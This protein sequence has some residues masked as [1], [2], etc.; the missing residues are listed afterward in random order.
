[1]NKK[2]FIIPAFLA[3]SLQIVSAIDILDLVLKPFQ[4]VYVGALYLRYVMFIDAVIYFILFLSLAQMV[5][6][7]AYGKKEGKLVAV[8]VGLA[9]MFGMMIFEKN[10]GFNLGQLGP[11]SAIIL[12]MVLGWLLYNLIQGMFNDVAASFSLTF[13]IMYAILMS[14]FSPLYKWLEAYS[15]LLAAILNLTMVAAFV[16][17]IIRII[18][19]FGGGNNNNNNGGGNG[20]TPGTTPTTPGTTP[21]TPTVPTPPAPS[22]ITITSPATGQNFNAG[23]YVRIAFNVAGPGFNHNYDYDVMIDGSRYA[24]RITNIGGNQV[25]P[26]PIRAGMEL[27][28]GRHLIQITAVSRGFFGGTNNIIAQSNVVEIT[29]ATGAGGGAPRDLIDLINDFNTATNELEVAYTEYARIFNEIITLN[30]AGN[31]I[32][33]NYWNAL[34][35]AR[36]HMID[37]ARE[38]NRILTAILNHASYPLLDVTQLNALTDITVRNINIRRVI[39]QYEIQARDDY[40]HRRAPRTPPRP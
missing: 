30:N 21:T 14:T 20:T 1:M 39:M 16:V 37:I 6:T 9:L 5:Y 24:A 10:S 12:L 28:A 19:M 7:K 11:L 23:D 17:L 33:P 25:C 34:L 4:E 2:L 40:N 26:Y 15:P 27:A 38:C 36:N 32:P 3:I 29:V 31:P 35:D 8:A 13:L 22:T 18:G